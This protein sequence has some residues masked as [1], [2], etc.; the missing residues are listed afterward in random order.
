MAERLNVN[1]P[2][3]G[4]PQWYRTLL[5]FQRPDR[6]KALWQMFNT[7]TLYALLWCLM[8]LNLRLYQS[9]WIHLGLFSVPVLSKSTDHVH[10]RAGL[11]L[12]SR[13]SV[14]RKG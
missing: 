7:F 12:F 3:G 10:S 14:S 5:Q 13:L 8:V 2:N 11:S 9:V 4:K 1:V 6:K